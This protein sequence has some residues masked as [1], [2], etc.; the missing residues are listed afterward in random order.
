[1][2]SF[3]SPYH[4]CLPN[5]PSFPSPECVDSCIYPALLAA[6]LD[7][8]SSARVAGFLRLGKRCD[9]QVVILSSSSSTSACTTKDYGRCKGGTGLPPTNEGTSCSSRAGSVAIPGAVVSGY[10]GQR[11]HCRR[12]CESGKVQVAILTPAY[13][14]TSCNTHAS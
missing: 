4:R 14:D 8:D 6:L 12:K 3:S 9:Q 2:Y 7:T 10:A 11:R 5:T 1:M 13:P